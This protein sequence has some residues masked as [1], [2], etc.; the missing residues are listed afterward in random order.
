VI[1]FRQAIILP[2]PTAQ[3]NELAAR[4][5]KREHGPLLHGDQLPLLLADGAGYDQ[6]RLNYLIVVNQ[7]AFP[8]VPELPVF[9]PLSP[10]EL[11]PSL[12]AGAD[13]LESAFAAD[14]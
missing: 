10:P 4:A 5:A 3:I 6:H 2:Q 7:S 13:E 11:P 14:L 12:L 1:R 8:F 9:P